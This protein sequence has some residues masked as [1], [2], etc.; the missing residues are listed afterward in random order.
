M[1]KLP[2]PD[3][4]KVEWELMNVIWRRK[5]A[6]VSDVHGHFLEKKRWSY[7][8]VKT[9]ME[10]LVRKGYLASDDSKVAHVYT[11]AVP[12]ASA[13]KKVLA[14]TLD[15]ILD[16]SLSPLVVYASRRR[17]LSEK[18]LLTLKA[19]LEKEDQQGRRSHD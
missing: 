18:E 6:T 11:A 12:R 15:R 17:N 7:T 14:E 13:V 2:L 5:N 3:L 1:D 8:T 10:R 16:D 19:L 9:M 4:T